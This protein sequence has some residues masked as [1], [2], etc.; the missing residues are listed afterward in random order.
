VTVTDPAGA[1]RAMHALHG[2]LQLRL[3]QPGRWAFQLGSDH[4]FV[5]ASQYNREA[6]EI[7]RD[8]VRMRRL[9]E[10]SGGIAGGYG[11]VER[12]AERLAAAERLS[13]SVRTSVPLVTETA[14]FLAVLL[15]LCGEWWWRRR[16]LGMV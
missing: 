2:Q 16:R 8:D 3:D 14:W 1:V 11:D 15:L 13:G 12:I 9:A 10:R 7:S 6:I 4:V 5:I